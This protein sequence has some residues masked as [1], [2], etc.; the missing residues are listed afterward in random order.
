VATFREF[1]L[2]VNRMANKEASGE[3]QMPADFFEKAPESFRERVVIIVN[4]VLAGCYTDLE[5][6][7]ILLCKDAPE[8]FRNYR[9]I[10]L[11]NAFYQLV[12]I[13]V[14]SRLKGLVER[15]SDLESSQFG[16]RNSRA[17]QHVIQKANW[18]IQ[19]VMKNDG[20]LIRGD[21][22]FKNAF[23]SAGHSCPWTILE[24]F[25]VP[26]VWWLKNIYEN[27]SMRVQVG[28]EYRG[29]LRKPSK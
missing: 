8:L 17:V 10:A 4:L 18:L 7:V 26:D 29:T 21:L 3:D 20:T 23:Y 6:R 16:L 2:F 11:C 12:N 13:I 9:P 1:N 22:E 19:E 24:G 25:G 28:G 15:S 5:A 14:T 27:S